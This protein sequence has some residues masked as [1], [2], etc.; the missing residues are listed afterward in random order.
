MGLNIF[1]QIRK[2]LF[3]AMQTF[4][5]CVLGSHLLCLLVIF[6]H[7]YNDNFALKLLQVLNYLNI[8]IN[9]SSR[10]VSHASRMQLR[11]DLWTFH[12]M[13]VTMGN[14][15]THSIQHR[16]R[17]YFILIILFS[18]RNV[19]NKLFFNFVFLIHFDLYF[20]L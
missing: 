3:H 13:K 11:I 17:L 1:F 19:E 16:I 8:F 7:F 9:F 20:S 4:Y 14:M 15:C 18:N 12:W 10:I 5:S 2:V 6:F